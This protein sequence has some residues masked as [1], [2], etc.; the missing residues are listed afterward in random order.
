MQFLC[1][2][3]DSVRS[4]GCTSRQ[5]R[6][7]RR[8]NF[9]LLCGSLRPFARICLGVLFGFRGP[10]AT[11]DVSAATIMHYLFGFGEVVG[12]YCVVTVGRGVRVYSCIS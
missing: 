12:A 8:F 5:L 9:Y 6:S 1:V 2:Y 10:D 7:G 11:G 4:S 3:V